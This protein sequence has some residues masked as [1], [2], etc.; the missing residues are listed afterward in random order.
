[1]A[2]CS[3]RNTSSVKMAAVLAGV[4]ARPFVGA[5]GKTE[6]IIA[7]VTAPERPNRN[8]VGEPKSV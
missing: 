1:M 4:R 8:G 2:S 7:Q 6:A 3:L 5:A